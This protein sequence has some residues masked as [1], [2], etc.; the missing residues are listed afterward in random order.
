MRGGSCRWDVSWEGRRRLS[1]GRQPEPRN[2]AG[3]RCSAVVALVLPRRRLRP[4]VPSSQPSR[5]ARQHRKRPSPASIAACK[6]GFIFLIC[7]N[8]EE[9]LSRAIFGPAGAT[10]CFLR[11][12][13]SLFSFARMRQLQAT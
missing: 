5:A 6:T 13:S 2:A 4:S 3:G 10:R 1:P 12:Q 8:N 7:G 9:I 11:A